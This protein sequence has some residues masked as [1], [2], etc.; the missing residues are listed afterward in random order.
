MP[1]RER[2]GVIC[3]RDTDILAIEQRDPTTKKRF[4]TFPGGALE[5]GETTEEGAIRETMEE[6]GYRVSLVGQC[7]TN[8]YTF[9]W[10]GKLFD[11]TTHWFLA[12]LAE[13]TQQPVDDADYILQSRWLPWPG[14]R[15]LFTFNTGLMNA[16]NN[17]L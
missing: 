8:Q 17:L 12:D 1:E 9:R 15:P 3:L 7:Y 6:T 13:E 16:I 11:C 5:P 4:W 2:T 10:N 14:S